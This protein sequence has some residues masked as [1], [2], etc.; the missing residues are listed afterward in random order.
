MENAFAQMWK[1]K[2]NK[3]VSGRMATYMTAIKRVVDA[4]MLRGI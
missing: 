4:M 3:K 1:M 2:E